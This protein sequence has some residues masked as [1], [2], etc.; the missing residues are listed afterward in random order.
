M[1]REVVRFPAKRLPVDHPVQPQALE[2]VRMMMRRTVTDGTAVRLKGSEWALAGKTGTA[3]LGKD[4]GYNKWMVG[5]APYDQPRYSV[6]VV[7]RSVP[8][9]GDPRALR[10][11][12]RVMEG[13]K[14]LQKK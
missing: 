5:F 4:G 6:A 2:Q 7:I 3:Q 13:L 14:A 11:F 9:D 1:T 8:D 10:V 12:Q